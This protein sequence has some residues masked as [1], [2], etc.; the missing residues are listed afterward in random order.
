MTPTQKWIIAILSLLTLGVF[1][2]LAVL[3]F[4][5]LNSPASQ[6]R[7][8]V[9]QPAPTA[10]ASLA[11]MITTEPTTPPALS[12]TATPLPVFTSPARPPATFAA[13]TLSAP[14]PTPTAVGVACP[15]W[16]MPQWFGFFD[17]KNGN[18]HFVGE[19]R[20]KGSS[21]RQGV[22]VVI[23]LFNR[24]SQY[25]GVTAAPLMRD[26]IQSGQSSPYHAVLTQ[27]APDWQSY[28]LEFRCSPNNAQQ[29]TAYD[30][31]EASSQGKIGPGSAY[32]IAGE[33]KNT[34]KETAHG[35]QVIA[36]LYDSNGWVINAL[37]TGVDTTTLAPG[38]SSTFKV[39]FDDVGHPVTTYNVYVQ[40][41]KE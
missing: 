28:S 5:R 14:V 13:T 17:D 26:V 27:P 38:A 22:T 15:D 39:G 35:V 41:K 2:L 37:R 19:A 1:A 40:G 16:D 29:N 33:V 8:I 25:V 11:A 12:L 18:T 24:T 21:T 9:T 10:A 36:V 32:T 31:L 20:N 3:V 7:A 30:G 6:D 34:G 23:R 4:T